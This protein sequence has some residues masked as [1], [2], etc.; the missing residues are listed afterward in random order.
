MGLFSK[1]KAAIEKAKMEQTHEIVCLHCF[2]NFKHNQVVFRAVEILDKPGYHAEV[3]ELLDR[4]LAR[5]NISP[6]GPL[7]PVLYPDN[8]GEANKG[9]IRD[10][11]SSLKDAHGNVST[12]RLCPYCHNE[13]PKSAGFQPC[14][15]ISIVGASRVGKSTYLASLITT[16]KNVTSHNFDVFCTPA[17]GEMGHRFKYEYEDQLLEHGYLLDRGT[18]FQGPLIFTFSFADAGKPELNIV[19]FDV[20]EE[21]MSDRGCMEIFAA[22]VTNS[23]GVIFLVDPQQF[24]NIS[25]KLQVLNKL[26]YEINYSSE[27]SEALTTL[28]ENYIAKQPNGISQIPTAVVLTKSDLLEALSYES[29]YIHPRS[30]IFARYTHRGYLNMTQTDI[31]NYE[32][33][34]FIQRADPNFRNALKRRFGNLGLFAVS[35]LGAR[36]EQI[37]QRA[38][39]FSPMR[40]D[41]PFLWILYRLR[42]IE[43]FYE[44]AR[45]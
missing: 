23:S 20:N 10:V 25:R 31:V 33:D 21:S 44:G 18:S 39:Q 3:D 1:K 12:K 30:N 14:T 19:F 35:A 8:F 34:E 4:H 42:C 22:H 5:F 29:D 9:Y 37:L 43:G 6:Q 32:V 2:A 28:L 15:L 24:R 40:V 41:E 26:N 11:L 45:L 7:P 16:L 27:P 17:S 36:P 38:A 13:I